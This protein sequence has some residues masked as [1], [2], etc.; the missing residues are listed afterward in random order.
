MG[1][2]SRVIVRGSIVL[3]PLLLGLSCFSRYNR[4]SGLRED[5]DSERTSVEDAIEER[6]DLIPILVSTVK[7]YA[8]DENAVFDA[9]T[10]ARLRLAGAI[11]ADELIEADGAMREAL[12]GLDALV[13][14]YPG[15]S[16]DSDF[17]RLGEELAGAEDRI[18][19]ERRNHADSVKRYNVLIEQFP[20]HLLARL[21]NF[22]PEEEAG[23]PMGDDYDGTGG[24]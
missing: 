24:N 3:L 23:E 10:A 4:M 9:I 1:N 19:E 2:Q 17:T 21:L 16:E 11:S 7:G 8:P 20:D 14:K 12:D 22:Q 13:D 15:L 18:I 5:I 6:N